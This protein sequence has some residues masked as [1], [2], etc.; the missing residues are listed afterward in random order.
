MEANKPCP[1]RQ[2]RPRCLC[3]DCED[4]AMYDSCTHGYCLHCLECIDRGEAVHDIYL[5]TGYKLRD[6]G[7]ERDGSD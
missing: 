6:D 4:N 7:G 5:C 2:T 3:H 1:F